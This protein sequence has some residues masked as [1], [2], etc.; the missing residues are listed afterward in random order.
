MFTFPNKGDTLD[1]LS[2]VRSLFFSLPFFLLW[3]CF[4][5]I[6]FDIVF[7]RK[8]HGQR[9]L[10]YQAAVALSVSG[11]VVNVSKPRQ[12]VFIPSFVF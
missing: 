12:H 4:V 6:C 10:Q 7:T 1:L 5:L 2:L 8:S 11:G 3:F 9:L